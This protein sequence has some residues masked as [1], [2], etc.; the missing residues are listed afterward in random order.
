MQSQPTQSAAFSDAFLARE[1][2]E[3]TY[4]LPLPD[5]EGSGRFIICGD[6]AIADGIVTAGPPLLSWQHFNEKAFVEMNFVVSGQLYQTHER[7]IRRR[8]FSRGY[9]NILFNPSSWEKNELADSHGFRN[10]GIHITPEKMI[11]LLTSYAPELYDLATKIEKG[12]PFVLHAPTERFSG[13]MQSLLDLLWKSPDPQGL[14][15]LHFESLALQLLCLQWENLIPAA[16]PPAAHNLRKA[17][18]DKLHDAQQYLLQ[19][20]ACPPTLAELSKLCELNEFKLKQGFRLLF[21]QSVFSFLSEERLENARQQI[22]QGEKNI[23]EIA[24]GLGYTHPQHFHRAFKKK[25]GIT[26]KGLLK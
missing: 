1:G 10:I 6:T 3:H 23:S 17:D 18:Q 26:P 7:L 24:Y 4:R 9:H 16:A 14:K 15:R 13:R 20:L 21:G 8:L 25:Y 2:V 22:L 19:H 11:S 12:I 5:A